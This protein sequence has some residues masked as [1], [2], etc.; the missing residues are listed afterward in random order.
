LTGASYYHFLQDDLPLLLDNALDNMPLNR[1]QELWFLNDGAPS[2]YSRQVRDFLKRTLLVI[3]KNIYY[4]Y[5]YLDKLTSR[6]SQLQVNQVKDKAKTKKETKRLRGHQYKLKK[7]KFKTSSRQY[8]LTN[9]AFETW[10]KL[11]NTVVNSA[12]VCA[13]KKQYD[14]MQ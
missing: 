8:F 9:R 13:F 6:M 11:D 14:K 10:N 7:E 2:H 5:Y 3:K 4:Y 1:R 12:N